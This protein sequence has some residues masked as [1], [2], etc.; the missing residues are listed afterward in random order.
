[1]RPTFLSSLNF[2]NRSF[3]DKHTQVSL[4]QMSLAPTTSVSCLVGLSYFCIFAIRRH[5]EETGVKRKSE[6]EAIPDHSRDNLRRHVADTQGT[7]R[8]AETMDPN[9]G[10][11]EHLEELLRIAAEN[12]QEVLILSPIGKTTKMT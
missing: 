8:P 3:C 2:N 5:V 6:E 9:D 10:V 4:I 7:K 12:S 1:M 11:T